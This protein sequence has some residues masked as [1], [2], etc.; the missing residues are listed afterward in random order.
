[1]GGAVV[2]TRLHPGRAGT[3]RFSAGGTSLPASRRAGL[4]HGLARRAHARTHPRARHD[5]GEH[6][7][8][9]SPAGGELVRSERREISGY[10][11]TALSSGSRN[12]AARM[13]TASRTCSQWSA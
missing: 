13:T 11:V 1:A 5:A 4:S 3:L 6:V 12:P 7:T 2:W 8:R 9:S 10:A